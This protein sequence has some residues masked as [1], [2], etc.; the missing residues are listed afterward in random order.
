MTGATCNLRVAFRDLAPDED[1]IWLAHRCAASL[2]SRNRLEL[3]IGKHRDGCQVRLH[4]V[5]SALTVSD[6]DSDP[7]LAV[8]NAFA[9]WEALVAELDQHARLRIDR[10]TSC[11][12]TS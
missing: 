5:D 9:R 12:K 4:S 11:A 1:V 3:T 8:R 10:R 6:S 2:L 7:F